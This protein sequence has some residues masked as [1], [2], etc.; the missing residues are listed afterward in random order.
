MTSVLKVDSIQTAAGKPIVNSTGSVLQVVRTYEPNSGFISTTSTSWT[1]SGI[2]AS[3]TPSVSGSIILIDFC[4]PLADCEAGTLQCK[5]YQSTA[6]SS[7]AIMS[8]GGL[9]H[10][11]IQASSTNRYSPIV[12]GGKYTTTSTAQV[13]FQPYFTSVDGASVRLVHSGSS[14][15]L[16]LTE[17]AA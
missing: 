17:I 12:F 8:G 2:T 6:G 7:Y 3:I 16:T 15:A 9:Y 10:A 13:S 5:M 11:G 1:A 4:V 14:Y